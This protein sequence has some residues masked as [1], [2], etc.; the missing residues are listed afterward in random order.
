VLC[1]QALIATR[2]ISFN[3]GGEDVKKKTIV[4]SRADHLFIRFPM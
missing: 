1:D 3:R 4:T 2:E